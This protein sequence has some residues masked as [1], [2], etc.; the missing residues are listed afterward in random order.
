MG[1]DFESRAGGGLTP[2][3]VH[4][5][6]FS[7]PP[8]GLRGYDEDQVDAFL[9][10]VEAA[11]RDPTGRSITP[12]EVRGVTFANPRIGKRGYTLSVKTPATPR[13]RHDV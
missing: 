2:E 9:D 8:F 10:R 13:E 5:I 4:N 11:L 7:K 6:A 12:E 3:Q 1:P